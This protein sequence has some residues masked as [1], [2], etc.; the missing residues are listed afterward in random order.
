MRAEK[1]NLRPRVQVRR[2]RQ[3]IK[4]RRTRADAAGPHV[5]LAG[6]VYLTRKPYILK[7]YGQLEKATQKGLLQYAVIGLPIFWK[8]RHEC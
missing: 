8:Q 2:A 6:H 4:R 1:E 3:V 7:H 5:G